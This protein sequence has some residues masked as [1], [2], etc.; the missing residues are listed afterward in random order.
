MA[1]MIIRNG[2]HVTSDNLKI[3][4]E[5]I[6]ETDQA[7]AKTIESWTAKKRGCLDCIRKVYGDSCL[8]LDACRKEHG[9]IDCEACF[10]TP[11]SCFIEAE[12]RDD[13]CFECNP[14][15]IVYD[16]D[17]DDYVCFHGER[18]WLKKFDLEC[19]KNRL[20]EIREFIDSFE[21]I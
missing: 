17:V 20:L 3:L 8:E 14:D 1:G 9:V 2:K 4:D 16:G 10:E 11:G 5:V 12:V 18:L 21:R 15:N 19:R 7:I 6:A 13:L